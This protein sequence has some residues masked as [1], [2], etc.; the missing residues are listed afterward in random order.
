MA[1]RPLID[2]ENYGQLR[3][4]IR[5][6][7]ADVKKKVREF[8]KAVAAGVAEYAPEFTPELSG[9]LKRS[10]KSGA[11]SKGGW[12]GAG[13]TVRVVYAPVIHWGWPARGIERS[14]FIIRGLAKAGREMGRGDLTNFYLEGLNEI[15]EQFARET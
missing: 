7:S 9:A 15:F 6:S 10:I 11:D 4:A 5:S 12:V 3:K 2:I 14:G 8:D 13:S 1:D